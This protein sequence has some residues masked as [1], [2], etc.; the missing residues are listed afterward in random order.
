M[1]RT[2][3]TTRNRRSTWPSCCRPTWCATTAAS[4]RS[5]RPSSP[6]QGPSAPDQGRQRAGLVADAGI[7]VGP[8]GV[9]HRRR[10]LVAR[11][12]QR[13][14]H[15]LAHSGVGVAGGVDERG[16][17]RGSRRQAR[18]TAAFSRTPA[19]ASPSASSRAGTTRAP[20]VIARP[21]WPARARASG[22][23]LATPA[24]AAAAGAGSRGTGMTDHAGRGARR[25]RR[26]RGRRR[27]RLRAGDDEDPRVASA[28]SSRRAAEVVARGWL[29]SSAT[30]RP[31][32]SPGRAISAA[33]RR[34]RR[35]RGHRAAPR[36][37]ATAAR[38]SGA[39]RRRTRAR[40]PAACRPRPARP[41]D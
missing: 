14:Q 9:N 33:A 20:G 38:R 13:H 30:R 17:M 27:G 37:S 19:S 23:E 7:G 4:A 10:P 3:R 26:G 25:A 2:S 18:P 8:R 16:T 40:R 34:G 6:R 12:R 35:R 39:R 15:L 36:H 22:C 32:S 29:P 5:C 28:G 41:A 11:E 1:R 31:S 21:A 24:S